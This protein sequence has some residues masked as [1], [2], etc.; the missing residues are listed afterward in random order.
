MCQTTQTLFLSDQVAQQAESFRDVVR[1]RRSFRRFLSSPIPQQKIRDVLA[2]AQLSPSNCNTQPWNMKIV[3]GQTLTSL[4]AALIH[5]HEDEALSPDFT[6]S[7]EEYEGQY[8]ERLRNQGRIYYQALGVHRQDREG[9][10][11]AAVRNYHFFNAPHAA[12]LFMPTVGDNVRVAS[13][14]GMYAQTF[15]LSLTAHGLGGIPQTTLGF[16]ADTVRSVL[17]VPHELRLLFGISF[18][19]PDLDARENAVR[20]GRESIDQSVTFH[21]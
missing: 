3:S 5:A 12:F 18:G 1:S 9:R 7:T 6:F 20:L 17:G 14:V 8:K 2:D 15:L 10:A 21:G 11:A 4:S 13:D 19:H 16:F